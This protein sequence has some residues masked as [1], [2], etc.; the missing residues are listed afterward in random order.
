MGKC[1]TVFPELRGSY[2]MCEGRAGWW[3]SLVTANWWKRTRAA[4]LGPSQAPAPAPVTRHQSVRTEMET[5]EGSPDTSLWEEISCPKAAPTF[6]QIVVIF[7]EVLCTRFYD[8]IHRETAASA[9]PFFQWNC[10]FC[11]LQ[12]RMENIWANLETVNIILDRR[13]PSESLL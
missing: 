9:F 2:V 10:Y 11:V 8:L 7:V 13:V 12:P 4:C 3:T 1:V 5:Q 6:W